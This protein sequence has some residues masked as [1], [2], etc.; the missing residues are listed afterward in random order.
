MC[1]VLA[2]AGWVLYDG[3]MNPLT[4]R[5]ARYLLIHA[6]WFICGL[7][8]VS[9]GTT[10]AQLIY[11]DSFNYPDG[12]LVGAGGSPWIAN[13]TPTNQTFVMSGT[14]FL[15]QTNQES[16]R[17]DFPTSFTTG[18]LYARMVANV[19][20]LP[21]GEGNFFAFFRVAGTDNLRARIWVTTN[22]AAPGKFRFGV[23]TIFVPP[24]IIA[25]D[26]YPGTNYTLVVR[27]FIV[28]NHT[29]L[30]V[31]P[32]NEGDTNN[33]AD[34]FTN[35]GQINMG[36]FGFAQTRPGQGATGNDIGA[37]T[38]DDL[39]IG[40][41]FAEVF[42]QVVFTSISNAPAGGYN[43]QASG[44]ATTNY[45]FQ[46]MTNLGSTNWVNLS[47][48]TA[49]TNGLFNVSDPDATNYAARFYRLLKQ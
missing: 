13:Y 38:V 46:A 14:L 41:T 43:L 18:A 7:L 19:S 34:D 22:G 1:S 3:G 6:S 24:T 20:Q 8:L 5:S 15:T 32:A 28:D 29:T 9:P 48:N 4:R 26:F 27:Y 35:V 30:W 25:Q 2:V 16:V 45:I 39:R 17:F 42:P 40:R 12:Q 31:N 23:T 47:T 37:V 21:A 36:H 10:K 11:A 44:Q 49:A 33:R